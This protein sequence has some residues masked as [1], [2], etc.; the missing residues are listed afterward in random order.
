M[1]H[2]EIFITAMKK[3][4]NHIL[5][6]DV[7]GSGIKGTIVDITTGELLFERYRIPTPADAK[8]KEIAEII[9]QIAQH[10]D[11]KGNVGCGFPAV[12]QHGIIKSAANISKANLNIDANK[13]FSDVLGQKVS[14]YNDADT[15]GYASVKF[16]AG[17]NVKGIVLLLTIGTGIGSALII[18]EKLVPNTEF[19]HVFMKNGIIA[20][21]YTS[22]AIR[23]REEL[24][25]KIWGERFNEYLLYMEKLLSPDLI[26][27]GGGTSKKI[28]KFSEKITIKTRVI[29][30]ELLNNAGVIGAACLA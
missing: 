2:I 16:G 12:I 20:E 24:D 8:P 15:A 13:L 28:Y 29:P 23:K 4:K 1:Y 26:I 9:K 27:I 19:G 18:D 14:V 3:N 7:G 30:A 21:K 10:F 6:V 11:Y 5:G 22:D 17:K 25:W